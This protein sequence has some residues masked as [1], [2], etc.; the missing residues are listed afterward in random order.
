MDGTTY[1]MPKLQQ[2]FLDTLSKKQKDRLFPYGITNGTFLE[3]WDF[4]DALST[5]RPV[6][7]DAKEGM[8]SKAVSE[9]IY[10]SGV[11]GQVVKVADVLSGKVSAYQRDV[12]KYWKL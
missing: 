12:D 11:S 10:E 2:L 9:A 5:G 1:S 7:I 3:L 8:R 4:I 6:E